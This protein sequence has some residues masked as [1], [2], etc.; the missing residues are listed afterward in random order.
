MRNE[1]SA[2]QLER[3]R[4]VVNHAGRAEMHVIVPGGISLKQTINWMADAVSWLGIS[5][6]TDDYNGVPIRV[7]PGTPDQPINRK[8]L[9]QEVEAELERRR[10]DYL[11]EEDLDHHIALSGDA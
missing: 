6:Y 3:F 8:R 4:V 10:Q 9:I 5:V 11:A 7:D 2:D 1:H